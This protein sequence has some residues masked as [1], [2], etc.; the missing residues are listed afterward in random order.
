MAKLVKNQLVNNQLVKSKWVKNKLRKNK[1]TKNKQ[2]G[3]AIV[4]FSIV[5]TFL[6]LLLFGIFSIGYYMYS[7][8]TL[9]DMTRKAAR[10]ASVCN[11][12]N[13]SQQEIFDIVIDDNAPVGFTSAN[14]VVE[15]LD[16]DS[17]VTAV[18]AD[19]RYVRARIHNYD[20]QFTS[21]LNFIGNDGEVTVSAFETTLP[22][23][24]LGVIRPNKNDNDGSNFDCGG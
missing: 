15:Y 20:Y 16:E 5:A 12:S 7:V 17:D 11:T 4:E 23:E 13:V 19:I 10:L 2:G 22:S 1:R 6:L 21:L 18:F 14:L 8:Q 24:S 3:L 9:N